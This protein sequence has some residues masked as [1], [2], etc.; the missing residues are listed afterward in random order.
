MVTRNRALCLILV[1]Q[2][3]SNRTVLSIKWSYSG[4]WRDLET[5]TTKYTYSTCTAYIQS[6][7]KKQTLRML[8]TH[9]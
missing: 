1:L 3:S 6:V 5:E 9:M 2:I 7:P 8:I 4:T